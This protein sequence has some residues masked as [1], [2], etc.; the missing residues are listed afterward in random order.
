MKFF[1]HYTVDY[2]L[3]LQKIINQFRNKFALLLL[4]CIWSVSLTNAQNTIISTDFNNPWQTNNSLQR[5]NKK[6]HHHLEI[7]NQNS[8]QIIQGFGASFNELGWVAMSVLS[9]DKRN[10]V[11]KDVFDTVEGCKFNICRMSIGANDF[12][13]NYY[14]LN[15]HNKDFN[16]DSFSIERDKEKLIPYIK[17]A[18]KYNPMLQVW[19]S[20]WTPPTWMKENMHFGGRV[21]NNNWGQYQGGNQDDIYYANKIKAE[22][23]YLEAYAL[24][25]KKFI[26]AYKKNNIPVYAI[27]PQNEVFANQLFPSCT[28][29]AEVLAKFMADY[30]IPTINKHHPEIEVWLGTIN[31]DSIE[32]VNKVLNYK[33]LRHKVA[34]VGV[35]WA[36]LRLMDTLYALYPEL[37]IMQT[38]SECNNGM[39]EWFTAEHTWDL[40]HHT[41]S[42]GGNAYMYWNLALDEI[43]L[44][45][46]MWRQNSM[47]SINKF[48]KEVVYNPEFYLMKHFSYFIERGATYIATETVD[49]ALVFQNPDGTYVIIMVNKE[50]Q[51]KVISLDIK[52]DMYAAT[53][54]PKT[55]NTIRIE[56]TE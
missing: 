49:N 37:K 56:K 51:S 6:Y 21:I 54:E 9:E 46:W 19:A 40:M 36:G 41:F 1:Y 13:L 26:D 39:N 24:Y 52:G 29:E 44:S 34:G 23:K 33:N 7:D 14:S 31:S 28:W 45:T 43:G 27:H 11:M 22:E 5:V 47:I 42:N 15:D 48:S 35:Q 32:Y 30:L 20:P 12:A 10:Q 38:E 3:I 2:M 18:L 25:F 55:F 17:T 50:K 4:V 16:M 53:L 8:K